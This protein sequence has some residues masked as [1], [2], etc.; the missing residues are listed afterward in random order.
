M[1]T[2]KLS[3]TKVVVITGAS[4]GIGY[5]LALYLAARGDIVCA[6]CRKHDDVN[7]MNVLRKSFPNL[8]LYQLDVTREES[9][10]K[11]IADII[12]D[13]HRID[14]LINNAAN[15]LFG[16]L[17]GVLLKQLQEQY[18]V[19]VFGAVRVIQEVL[20]SMRKRQK[21]HIIFM[22]ST[23]GVDC[24]PMYAAYASSKAALES[25]A[26]SLAA[27]LF[28]WKIKVSIIENSA[29]N[30]EISTKSLKLGMRFHARTNPYKNYIENSLLFLQ[31]LIA[32]GQTPESVAETIA[33]IIDSPG[34]CLRELITEY[35]KEVFSEALKDPEGLGWVK[36]AKNEL[37]WFGKDAASCQKTKNRMRPK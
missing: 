18:D 23:S 14:V 30:T 21:G 36:T 7:R 2:R 1:S 16:P 32:Q 24:V 9:V 17:E 37:K 22:G 34:S 5:C 6:T 26:S 11:S 19:N 33:K 27:N 12:D 31:Q 29:T 8:Y 4:R 15:I 13:H 3:N 10:K 25:I 28:L 20:P 35:S